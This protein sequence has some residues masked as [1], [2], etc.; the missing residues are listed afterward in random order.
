MKLVVLNRCKKSLA[1]LAA[2]SVILTATGPISKIKVYAWENDSIDNVNING[3]FS[4]GLSDDLLVH[5]TDT[6][7]VTEVTEDGDRKIS[8][9]RNGNDA[10]TGSL[11]KKVSLPA[12]DYVWQFELSANEIP[13]T[14]L[15]YMS[16]F[17]IF[18]ELNS[19]DRGYGTNGIAAAATYISDESYENYYY[20]NS[21][22]YN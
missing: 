6:S 21:G 8:I 10:A 18:N 12:G 19:Y 7:S 22:G 2:V 11:S 4:S 16:Y 13:T 5:T 3:D 17:G 1:I 9:K 15:S 14:D 20:C